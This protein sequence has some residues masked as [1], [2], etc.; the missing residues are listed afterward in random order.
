LVANFVTDVGTP[1]VTAIPAGI[2]SFSI[3]ASSNAGQANQTI[4]QIQVGKYDGT[5]APTI[6]ATSNDVSIYDPTVTAQYLISVVI[7][8]GT[9][10]ARFCELIELG[11]G[12]VYLP[13]KGKK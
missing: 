7:P 9:T 11:G 2:W 1:G 3:W 10:L 8:A 5:N 6:I 13:R 12:T 4:L